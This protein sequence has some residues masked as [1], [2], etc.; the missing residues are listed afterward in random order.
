MNRPQVSHRWR[1]LQVPDRFDWLNEIAEKVLSAK[2]DIGIEGAK[3][4]H[5]PNHAKHHITD[6]CCS[7]VEDEVRQLV[8]RMFRKVPPNRE[9]GGPLADKCIA[10]SIHLTCRLLSAG[11]PQRE[12]L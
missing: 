7:G 8:E 1:T 9:G 5:H 11:W 3:L 12:L 4:C 10:L 6:H 2:S